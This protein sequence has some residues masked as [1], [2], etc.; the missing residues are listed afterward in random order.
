[1]TS[2]LQAANHSHIFTSALHA[3]CHRAQKTE[4]D[5][6]SYALTFILVILQQSSHL[7]ELPVYF[8]AEL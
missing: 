1:M 6:L 7:I 2:L 3:V 4:Q 8:G 5:P